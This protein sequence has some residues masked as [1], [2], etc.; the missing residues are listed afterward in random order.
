[1]KRTSS[2]SDGD[3]R[4]VHPANVNLPDRTDVVEDEQASSGVVAESAEVR[5]MALLHDIA[6][7]EL[8][9]SALSGGDL[10]GF[11]TVVAGEMTEAI[12]GLQGGGPLSSN[13]TMARLMRRAE[14]L[15]TDTASRAIASSSGRTMPEEQLAR[16]EQAFDHDFSH[17]RVH[18][19]AAAARAAE[20]LNAHAFALGSEIYFGAVEFLPG[21]T[22]GDRVLA[23][24]LTHVVQHDEGRLPNASEGLE[25]SNPSDSLERE[26]YANEVVI[27]R[28]LDQADAGL[29]EPDVEEE[30]GPAAMEAVEDEAESGVAQPV[31]EEEPVVEEGEAAQAPAEA[32]DTGVGMRAEAKSEEAG[33]REA[34]A[35]EK[36]PTAALPS[37]AASQARAPTDLLGLIRESRGNHIPDAIARRLA[38]TLGARIEDVVVHTDAPANA[39]AEALEARAFA[40]GSHVFFADGAYQPDSPEGAALLAEQLDLSAEAIEDEVP[41][42]IGSVVDLDPER[43]R[44]TGELLAKLAQTLRLPVAAIPVRVDDD[45]EQRTAAEGTRGLMEGGEVLLDPTAYDPETREGRSLLAHE[46]V[47]V[48]Q[49]RL[50]VD[51]TLEQPGEMAEAEAHVAAEQFAAGAAMVT[52][53]MGIPDS[54]VAAEGGAEN[55][56][57]AL[58]AYEQSTQARAQNLPQ[59]QAPSG[60]PDSTAEEDSEE[61]LERYEDGVDGVADLIED[62]DAFDDLCDAYDDYEGE[63]RRTRADRA[64][65]RIRPSEPFQQLK[66]MWQG[67]QEGG[68]VRSQMIAAFNEEFNG[69]GF[70]ESTEQA[71]DHVERCAKAEAQADAEA[72]AARQAALQAAQEGQGEGE[73]SGEGGEGGAETGTASNSM[74]PG[75]FGPADANLAAGEVPELAPQ[76]AEFE[77]MRAVTDQQLADVVVERNHQ[78]QLGNDLAPRGADYGRGSQIMEAFF[79]SFVGDFAKAFTDGFVDAAILDTLGMLGDK[80]LTFASRGAVRTPMI[81][82]MI[83]MIQSKPWTPEFYEGLANKGASGIEHLGNIGDTLSHLG[84]AE[85]A[86]DVIGILC[87]AFADLFSGLRDLLDMVQQIVGTLSALCYIVGGICII[88]GLAL[89]WLAGVGA[90]FVTAGGWLVRAGGILARINSALGIVVLILSALAAVFRT[91]AAFL[92]PAQMYASQLGGVS[93]AGG[94]F[95]EKAG[96]KVGDMAGS[97]TR[98]AISNRVTRSSPSAPDGETGD[99][100]ARGENDTNRV[101]DDVDQANRDLEADTNRLR[102]DV[103]A[104][105]P[106]EGE[107]TTPRDGEEGT[108]PRDGEEGQR[109]RDDGDQPSRVRRFF[110]AVVR[111]VTNAVGELVNSCRDLS[112]LATDPDQSAREGLAPYLRIRDNVTAL[113]GQVRDL[114]RQLDQL[115]D[116]SPDRQR[117][118]TELDR[119][120]RSLERERGALERVG[121]RVEDATNRNN[122]D[123][124]NQRA[125]QS[126][127]DGS[128]EGVQRL[129]DEA[130]AK[131]TE[132]ETTQ[133]QRDQLTEQIERTNSELET[134]R[135]NAEVEARARQDAETEQG[136]IR[137]HEEAATARQQAGDLEGQQRGLRQEADSLRGQAADAER[138][139]RMRQE[140]QT[141]QDA[142]DAATQR[143]DDA[144]QSMRDRWGGGDSRI[145]VQV[146][147]GEGGQTT[148]RRRVLEIT[149]DGVVVTEGRGGRR[150]VPFDQ[151]EVQAMRAQGDE[152]QRS[153]RQ[154]EQSN[155]EAQRRNA[156]ADAIAPPDQDPTALRERANAANEQADAMQSQIDSAHERSQ[157]DTGRSREEHEAALADARARGE[158]AAGSGDAV[159]RLEGQLESQRGERTAADQRIRDLETEISDLERRTRDAESMRHQTEYVENSS[160]GNAP[161][162]VGSAYKD[163]LEGPF[164]T[165]ITLLTGT[166]DNVLAMPEA[167]RPQSLGDAA[168]MGVQALGL[169]PETKEQI[170]RIGNQQALI[171]ELLLFPPPVEMESMFEHR[172]AARQAADQYLVS[173]EQSYRCYVAEQA[174][175]NM[176]ADTETL[177]NAGE[178]IV[179]AAQESQQNVQE[180]QAEEDRRASALAGANTETP[181]QDSGFASLVADLI[182]E[183]ADRGDATEGQPNAGDGASGEQMANAQGQAGEAATEE[184]D[185]ARGYSDEQRAL[186]DQALSFGEQQEAEAQCNID[187]LHAKHDEEVAIRDE[188]TNQK[189]QALAEREQH[190]STVVDEANAFISDFTALAGWAEE[191]KRRRELIENPPRS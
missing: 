65:S 51:D 166:R 50:P 130:A 113:E 101:R 55:L 39:A 59:T 6:G 150:L 22:R 88:F 29:S 112:R 49:D 78:V 178:P 139:G 11:E 8:L 126:R 1:M 129:Q 96:A 14:A 95:G 119:A 177:A 189:N 175:T 153:R 111:P 188:I 144:L 70:W 3:E 21:T 156:E 15:D 54:H 76:I 52:P 149:D 60:S 160:S 45:S 127:Q 133:Q 169:Q 185:A 155:T 68:E 86:G 116:S 2:L 87:A 115:A 20:A 67:A 137:Q 143:A 162:G 159:T 125:N 5:T 161:G 184:T 47:H 141:V 110:S 171:E 97:A 13:Q 23:H 26:A 164:F 64:M 74:Q 121:E 157:V 53:S 38:A 135:Q 82:P 131:Q 172:D 32:A 34:V 158:R 136:N 145:P 27:L 165:L 31:V 35:D 140:A 79:D 4:T 85:D 163:L 19:D 151:V 48:A 18:T 62:L 66:G 33:D 41:V 40:L 181:E 182:M 75:A 128:E 168:Q 28:Q 191:Y 120:Q 94:A 46:V 37:G 44:R 103:E 146:P 77:A 30:T 148:S 173:H 36:V 81:G 58:A 92:V 183:M 105:H 108:T 89:L 80:V 98:D 138:A 122:Q 190:K 93:E 104:Q 167:Q 142:A 124:A 134:A 43:A 152:L 109:P 57:T 72:E 176:A 106:A 102:E 83:Q 186:L 154:A 123:E 17:V 170:Q 69:R 91:A 24:E 132:R 99:G 16:M 73:G 61:K 84:E 63:E 12:A 187:Q 114:S 117:L 25:V 71:F 180:G 118:A 174:V 90:P 100:P 56:A 147:D 9:G 10:G 7:N 107:G 42:R 179:A